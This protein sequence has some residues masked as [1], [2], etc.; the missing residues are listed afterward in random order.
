[1]LNYKFRLYP[2]KEQEL[3]LGHTLNGCRWVYN[4]FLSIPPMS[5]YDMN[6]ALTE[7]KE[8]HPWLRNYHS[9]MLQMVGKQVAAARKVTTGKLKY[10]RDYD[11]NA[12]TYNQTG[13]RLD[14]RG[15]LIL[16]KVGRIKILLHRQPVNVKQV[17]VCRKYGKWYAI[18]ACEIL[19]SSYSNIIYKKPVG[20]DVGIAKFAHD[21]D[22]HVIENPQFLS[23][24]LKPLR[25]AHRIKKADRQQQPRESQTHA[26]Q[27][28]R[29]HKQQAQRLFAQNIDVLCQPL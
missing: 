21:S 20:I 5:E 16:S 25:R 24:M 17:T 13:F 12:F 6:Y 19:R 23:R 27:P 26:R 18:A 15:V 1:M 29:A 9:K 22:N 3:V 7:L 2:T 14:N 11:Y 10:R 8:Q 4:Y 28:V